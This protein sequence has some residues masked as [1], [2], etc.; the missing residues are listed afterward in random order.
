LGW[1]FAKAKLADAAKPYASRSSPWDSLTE[2]VGD[3]DL[4]DCTAEW[5]EKFI[6][7]WDIAG[8]SRLTKMNRIRGALRAA[9]ELY[10]GVKV[11]WA[12]LNL[13]RGRLTRKQVLKKYKPR[14]RRASEE[15]LDLLK[16]TAAENPRESIFP[17]ADLIDFAVTTCMRR[18]E[19]FNAK[20]SDVNRVKGVPMLMIRN[21]K[22]PKE[23]MGNDQNIPLLGDALAIINRQPKNEYD[24]ERIFPY[25]DTSFGNA[26]LN[27]C[28]RAKI[29][30]LHYH[31]LRHE[32][33]SR[34]FEQGFTI[35]EVCL[36]S[37]H[38]S[39]EC[40]KVYTNLAGS[41]MHKGP[42]AHRKAA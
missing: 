40:L 39:W 30:N 23:K 28:R 9:E 37:G 14:T 20:W 16:K 36:V 35:P 38:T 34:L 7:S 10:D 25:I 33:V 22:H 12:A 1:V 19:I 18:E 8:Y 42:L 15:E 11:D 3:V 21:R 13:A 24:P 5:W 4:K 6:S 2:K 29:E 41:D 32:G 27:L 31:D 26:F 17:Y